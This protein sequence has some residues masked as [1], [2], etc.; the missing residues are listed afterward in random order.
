MAI[1]VFVI[2]LSNLIL[3]ISFDKSHDWLPCA[4]DTS[5]SNAIDERE[6]QLDRFIQYAM[7]S[8][9]SYSIESLCSLFSVGCM[10]GSIS[11]TCRC[12]CVAN[13]LIEIKIKSIWNQ[14]KLV[15]RAFHSHVISMCQLVKLIRRATCEWQIRSINRV[16]DRQGKCVWRLEMCYMNKRH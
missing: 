8:L 2:F 10:G 12:I 5:L 9:D 11:T 6:R 16:I 14:S 7:V 15:R 3:W 13:G 4:T 1:F